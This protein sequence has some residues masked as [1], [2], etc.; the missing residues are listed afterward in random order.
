MLA[1]EVCDQRSCKEH[2]ERAGELDPAARKPS[3]L[4][5]TDHDSGVR[6]AG[7]FASGAGRKPFGVKA[8]GLSGTQPAQ[9]GIQLCF[10]VIGRFFQ[11]SRTQRWI[12]VGVQ[13]HLGTVRPKD[14]RRLAGVGSRFL[15]AETLNHGVL[16]GAVNDCQPAFRRLQP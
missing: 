2:P 13:L 9:G 5:S 11:L 14:D 6:D 4:Q 10:K 16:A 12:S 15:I 8:A 1:V 3:R 7:E